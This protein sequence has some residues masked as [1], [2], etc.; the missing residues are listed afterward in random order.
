MCKLCKRRLI[1]Q[2]TCPA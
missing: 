1:R 2:S